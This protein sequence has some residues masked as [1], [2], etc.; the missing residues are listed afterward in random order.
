MM[1]YEHVRGRVPGAVN[2]FDAP[3]QPAMTLDNE[4]REV[5]AWTCRHLLF[6]FRS[7]G[8]A[9]HGNENKDLSQVILNMQRALD[10]RARFYANDELLD[11]TVS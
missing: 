5:I 7:H 2:C 6:G 4:Q 3:V 1:L 9:N 8:A 10:Y 11:E